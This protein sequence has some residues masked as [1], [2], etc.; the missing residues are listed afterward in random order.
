M[1]YKILIEFASGFDV[2]ERQNPDDDDSPPVTYDSVEAAE[3]ELQEFIECSQ[4][5]NSKGYLETP[6]YRSEFQI[7]VA[8]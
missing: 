2:F 1:K 4:F 6:Y 8:D 5:A 7:V 3:T